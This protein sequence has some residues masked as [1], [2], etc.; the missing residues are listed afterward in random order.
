MPNQQSQYVKNT[1]AN[2]IGNAVLV[3]L[4]LVST[5]LLI[6][7][8]GEAQ[9]GLYRVGLVSLVGYSMLL[10]LGFGTAVRR[11]F[12]EAFN[13]GR[14][15]DANEVL[16]VAY[17]FHGV[18]SLVVLA[19]FASA[20]WWL[21]PLVKTPPEY[22]SA[23]R[24]LILAS[25]LY[26]SCLFMLSPLKGVL[27]GRHRYDL[28]EIIELSFR[29]TL[30]VGGLALIYFWRP[31]LHAL[32]ISALAGA[33]LT[34]GLTVRFAK[35]VYPGLEIQIGQWNPELFKKLFRFGRYA[36]MMVAGAM[37][38]VQSPDVLIA[39]FLGPDRVAAYAVAAILI[40]QLRAVTDAFA[41]PLFPIASRLKADKDAEGLKRLL[42]E[43]TRRCLWAWGA[44][45]CPVIVFADSM[46]G[47]W[48]GLEYASSFMIVWI[49]LLGDLGSAIHHSPSN[50]LS[51]VGSIKWLGYSHLLFSG[52]SLV[53]IVL[54]LWLTPLGI[55]G[56]AWS[57]AIPM[58]IRGGIIVPVYACLQL[59]IRPWT[60]YT[61][62][63][64]PCILYILAGVGLCCVIR[65][66]VS[67]SG[68]I[69]VLTVMALCAGGIA[70]AGLWLML[71][72]SERQRLF[73]MI[74]SI[75]R[76]YTG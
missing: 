65:C 60:Y 15:R 10:N 12:S 67:P 14:I 6:R 37:I 25:G 39:A 32:A 3:L 66:W 59:R 58:L 45:V 36:M 40:A 22:L 19:G 52:A 47:A 72:G 41:G 1:L 49:L 26:V 55:T 69:P 51:A 21:P 23:F 42:L 7:W 62:N 68:L 28:N 35:R 44:L 70:L 30:M 9:Y 2:L 43:G 27:M 74:K 17:C 13:E 50:I 75:K 46:I 31:S 8:L 34:A 71:S 11:Y 64:M 53:G 4:F 24:V 54:V 48:I 18:Q 57:L 61:Y 29:L 73:N 76:N 16:S 56:V 38:L 33:I 63:I 5:P 20:I